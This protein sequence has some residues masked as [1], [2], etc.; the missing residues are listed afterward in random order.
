MRTIAVANRKGGEGKTIL[1]FN[2]IAG[3]SMRGHKVLAI[4]ADGQANLTFLLGA[5]WQKPGM[6]EVLSGKIDIPQAVQHTKYADVLA[7]SIALAT[8]TAN[9]KRL[10]YALRNVKDYDIC[11]IDCAPGLGLPMTNA[12]TAAHEVIIP[13]QADTLSLQGL[14]MITETIRQVQNGE[15]KTNPDLMVLGAVLSRYNGR[16]NVSRGMVKAIQSNC[17]ALHIPYIDTPIREAA[18]VKEAAVMRQ[19]VLEYAPTSKP[20]QDFQNLL[21]ALNI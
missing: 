6:A 1:A 18:A 15:N 5:D 12:L 19:S 14:Y 3:A 8:A 16:S 2:L 9:A 17:D 10:Q 20:A 4:D 21:D 11:I 7:G 13:L